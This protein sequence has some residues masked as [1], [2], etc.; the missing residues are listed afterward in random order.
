MKK[1]IFRFLR[2]HAAAGTLIAAIVATTGAAAL[3][4][5]Q[6]L[7]LRGEA[8]ATYKPLPLRPSAKKPVVRASKSS[9]KSSPRSAARRE[10]SRR[11]QEAARRSAGVSSIR[12]FTAESS[13]ASSVRSSSV[14]S[15]S[16]R[17]QPCAGYG[18]PSDACRAQ[19]KAF[20][21]GDIGCY[22]DDKCKPH[23]QFYCGLG[24]EHCE[25]IEAT[26]WIVESFMPRCAD[27]FD[28]ECKTAH[29]EFVSS[30]PLAVKGCMK[31]VICR[32]LLTD[33]RLGEF[34]CR[35]YTPCLDALEAVVT[36][37]TCDQSDWCRRMKTIDELYDTRANECA[38]GPDKACRDKIGV[39]SKAVRDERMDE[40]TRCIIDSFCHNQLKDIT[41]TLGGDR[42]YDRPNP[43]CLLWKTCRD[44]FEM[45][46]KWMCNIG[47]RDA[48]CRKYSAV[49]DYLTVTNKACV[50]SGDSGAC[51]AGIKALWK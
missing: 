42:E 33:F 36:S 40:S 37:A 11:T 18:A 5:M 22:K 16:V 48:Q 41:A 43:A 19:M 17:A 7:P 20:G 44:T 10:T 50:K 3:E 32:E 14:A 27:S 1:S 49:W 34:S 35:Y 12:A 9:S 39:T 15:S 2:T 13:V 38:G 21:A 25:P 24:A 45:N 23:L 30:A 4:S 31:D 29:A 26:Q 8:S 46:K 47:G 6:V 51:Q 28:A